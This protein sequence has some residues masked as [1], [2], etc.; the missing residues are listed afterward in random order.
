M[1]WAVSADGAGGAPQRLGGFRHR[2]ATVEAGHYRGAL[3]RRQVGNR[4]PNRD[5]GR[6]V[7]E[8]RW[9]VSAEPRPHPPLGAPATGGGP[10]EVE[11]RAIR[12]RLR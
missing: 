6:R 7:R 12:P 11:R 1:A 5:G 9:A 8:L 2:Q 10:C 3:A 4:R